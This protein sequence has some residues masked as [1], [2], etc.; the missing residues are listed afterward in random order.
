MKKLF[1]LVILLLS[2]FALMDSVFYGFWVGTA[3]AVSTLMLS[4]AKLALS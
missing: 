3:I 2:M 1:W 4:S